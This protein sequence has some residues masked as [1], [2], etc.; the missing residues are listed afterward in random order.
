V[1]SHALC[2]VLGA[3]HAGGVVR[4]PEER[5]RPAL[6]FFFFSFL[7]GGVGVSAVPDSVFRNF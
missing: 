2:L 5:I 6:E 7:A 1:E 3:D 4:G